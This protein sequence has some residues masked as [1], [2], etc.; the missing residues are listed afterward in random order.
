MRR[1]ASAPAPAPDSVPTTVVV[2]AA[3]AAAAAVV[4]VVLRGWGSRSWCR[5]LLCFVVHVDHRV[6]GGSTRRAKVS[7]APGPRAGINGSAP[8]A[9]SPSGLSGRQVGTRSGLVGARDAGC[10]RA[11]RPGRTGD[12]V[13][14][15]G[16]VLGGA[17]RDAALDAYR[18]AF[19]RVTTDAQVLAVT[20]GRSPAGRP[21]LRGAALFRTWLPIV[22]LAEFLGFAVPLWHPGQALT[23]TVLIGIAGGLLMAATTAA[24]PGFALRRL[25]PQR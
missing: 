6:A 25:L 24:V 17:E 20:I 19:P 1:T 8:R 22:T 13:T 7:T 23:A 5:R 18:R 2:A 16:A 9:R 14:G 21:P 15:S 10:G 12:R 11:G 3:P 4:R